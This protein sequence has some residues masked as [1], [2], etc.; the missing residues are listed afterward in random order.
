MIR[1]VIEAALFYPFRLLTVLS[2]VLYVPQ[3]SQAARNAWWRSQLLALGKD[4]WI[5]SHVQIH[6]PDRVSIGTRCTVSD[7]VHMWGGGGITIGDQVMI[8]SHCVITSVTHDS[9][10]TVYRYTRIDA[11]VVIEDNVWIGAGAIILP[12]VRVGAGSIVGAGSVVT[13][14]VPRSAV[15]VGLPARVTRTNS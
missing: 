6:A 7:F 11:P 15:V 12:G 1:N 3:L 9:R 5:Y 8:G 2:S 4:S 14:D 13:R 10:A